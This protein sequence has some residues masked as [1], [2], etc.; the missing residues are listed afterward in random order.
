MARR[1]REEDG[2]AR[3]ITRRRRLIGECGGHRANRWSAAWRPGQRCNAPLSSC[4]AKIWLIDPNL[5]ATLLYCPAVEG[6]VYPH[7]RERRASKHAPRNG[8]VVQRR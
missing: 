1:A 8:Q 5:L 7:R 6:G 3:R 2:N 4:C